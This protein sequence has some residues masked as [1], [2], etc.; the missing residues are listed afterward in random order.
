[1]LCWLAQALLMQL[2]FV[3]PLAYIPM[4]AAAAYLLDML[5]RKQPVSGTSAVP[6]QVLPLDWAS[7]GSLCWVVALATVS[8]ICPSCAGSPRITCMGSTHQACR[9]AAAAI[10]DR[11]VRS[12]LPV[13]SS[14]ISSSIP[15][16]AVSAAIP[17]LISTL[18]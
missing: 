13:S 8:S 16:A 3:G 5:L 2:P 10:A 4:Q 15:P 1:M 6:I 17:W 7:P 14:A 11:A 18:L 9:D 12:A